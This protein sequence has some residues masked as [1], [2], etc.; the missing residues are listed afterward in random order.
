MAKARTSTLRHPSPPSVVS[1]FISITV[2]RGSLRCQIL[3]HVK[4]IYKVGLTNVVRPVRHKVAPAGL[5]RI[6]VLAAVCC[7]LSSS[8]TLP[9]CGPAG[10]WT[11]EWSARLRPGVGDRAGQYGYVPL[12]RHL[13]S[14]L[15]RNPL[16]R[17]VVGCR[18]AHRCAEESENCCSECGN[19]L[20][21][22]IQP[23]VCV[24]HRIAMYI[25]LTV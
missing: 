25:C 22:A 24:S 7:R 15:F 19:R 10:R 18:N 4:Y 14:F 21:S 13:V 9:A 11:R 17:D 12:G 5:D 8:V 23:A 16:F 1:F 20:N 2:P 6:L 3:V